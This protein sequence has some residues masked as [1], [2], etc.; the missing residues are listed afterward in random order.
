MNV[1]IEYGELAQLHAA[2]GTAPEAVREELEAAITEA[3]LLVLREVQDQWPH[4][5]GISRASMHTQEVVEGLRV[6][7]FVGSP[8]HYVEA[9]DLG[10]RPHFPPIDALVDW[11]RLRFNVSSEAQAEGIA[12]AI[13]W[14]IYHRGTEGAH[15]LDTV[16]THLY[17]QLEQIFDAAQAR[18][19]AR[20]G[21]G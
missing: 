18:I 13:A 20:V 6:E 4:A 1:H 14:K 8:L 9:A 10:T 12:R 7:G 15:A 16:L 19:A 17:P 3:D 21:L 2:L 11:V 5:S